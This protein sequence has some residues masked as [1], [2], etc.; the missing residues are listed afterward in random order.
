MTHCALL[1]AGRH[2]WGDDARQ[3]I[4]VWPS[5]VWRWKE[6]RSTEHKAMDSQKQPTEQAAPAHFTIHITVLVTGCWLL[7]GVTGTK[8]PATCGHFA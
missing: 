5:S 8:V 7:V 1:L 6:F 2:I 4:F 3:R